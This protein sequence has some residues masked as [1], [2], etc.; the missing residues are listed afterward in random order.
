MVIHRPPD[1]KAQEY[2]YGIMALRN[3]ANI[4][5]PCIASGLVDRILKIQLIRG[6]LAGKL[7]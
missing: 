3:H 2:L 4:E 5:Q 1:I 6:T 7:A